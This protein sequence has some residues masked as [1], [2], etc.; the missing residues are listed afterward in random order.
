MTYDAQAY[1]LDRANIHDTITKLCHAYDTASPTTLASEV[2]AP[3]IGLDYA[4]F[5]GADGPTS[6]KG[7][8]WSRSVVDVLR[9][10]TATQHLLAGVVANLP[11]PAPPPPPGSAPSGAPRPDSCRAVANVFAS[12]VREGVRGGGGLMQNGGRYEFE[13]VRIA[14]LEDEGRNPWRIRFHKAVATWENGNWAVFSPP[15]LPS[16]YNRENK[17]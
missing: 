5:F 10:M 12:L 16:I 8:E 14:A 2:Y 11:Q 13:L 6:A 4:A 7:P 1:L 15:D 3:E 17:E 9:P